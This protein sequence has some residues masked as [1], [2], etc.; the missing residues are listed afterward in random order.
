MQQS[1]IES[2]SIARFAQA[3]E[4]MDRN[5]ASWSAFFERLN[6]AETTRFLALGQSTDI[7]SATVRSIITARRLRDEHFWPAMSESAW[8]L[9][10][11]MFA[12]SL[13][14]ERKDVAGLS[15]ETGL[16]VDDVDHWI[17]WLADRG[18][19]HRPRSLE[20]EHAVWL[21]DEASDRLR[22]YLLASLELS[23]GVV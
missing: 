14:G 6:Q 23:P 10:L 2:E 20:S 16:A 3:V 18:M 19:V 21:T 4:K 1:S 11:E 13:T 5:L 8:T 22:A 12:G 9:L 7:T 17:D 15:R